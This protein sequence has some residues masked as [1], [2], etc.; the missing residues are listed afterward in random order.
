[1]WACIACALM[2]LVLVV[3]LDFAFWRD[4]KKQ[5]RGEKMIE[6]N[7]VSI[8]IK[9]VSLKYLTPWQTDP[10]DPNFRYTY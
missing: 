9:N 6:S 2:N 1:M 3:L 4:N 10:D 7:D 5:A 8:C